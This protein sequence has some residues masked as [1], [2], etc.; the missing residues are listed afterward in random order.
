MPRHKAGSGRYLKGGSNSERHQPEEDAAE[1]SRSTAG[2]NFPFKLA[3][4]D[5]GQCDRNRCTG[6]RL[7]RQGIVRELRLGQSHPGVVLSPS[8]TRSVSMEDQELM[9]A[10][11]L[12]V[13]DCSWNKLDDVPFGASRCHV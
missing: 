3:M 4:W 2:T 1:P 11:G 7:A 10:K 8:G 12:A 9:R 13:V 6:T 5:L